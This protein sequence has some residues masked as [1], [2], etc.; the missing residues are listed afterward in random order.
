MAKKFKDE[1]LSRV[2]SHAHELI[3]YGSFRGRLQCEVGCVNQAAYNIPYRF[4]AACANEAAA[5]AFDGTADRKWTPDTILR[6]LEKA[7]VA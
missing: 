2:L 5:D 1:E 3:R 7:G 4:S 6:L